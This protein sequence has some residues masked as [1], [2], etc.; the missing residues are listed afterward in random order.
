MVVEC[1]GARKWLRRW[2]ATCVAG[3]GEVKRQSS[4][5][6]LVPG[7]ASRCEVAEKKFWGPRGRH[8]ELLS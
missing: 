1:I 3:G 7:V 5:A 2:V 4:G 8:E 6:C